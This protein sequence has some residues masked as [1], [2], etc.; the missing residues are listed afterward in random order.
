[1]MLWNRG[2]RWFVCLPSETKDIPVIHSV[3]PTIEH[4]RR[5]VRGWPAPVFIFQAIQVK[6]RK[7]GGEAGWSTPAFAGK[8]K[9]RAEQG[10]PR[11]GA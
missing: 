4:A 3:W 10:P 9:P 1:M 11:E 2:C 5:A 8:R 7:S 6:V